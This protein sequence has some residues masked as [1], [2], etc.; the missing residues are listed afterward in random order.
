VRDTGIGIAP[1][2]LSLIFDP[3][4][5]ADASTTRHY[6]GTGL[7]M[8]ICKQLVELMGGTLGV[9]S[10]LGKGSTFWFTAVF[11]KQTD[12]ETAAAA[13]H[14]PAEESPANP[15]ANRTVQQQEPRVSGTP[16][17]LLAEDDT[18]NQVVIR[19][20]L[21][22]SG[23]Q[24]DLATNGLEAVRLLEQNDYDLVLM[25]CMMPEMDGYQATATIRD[26]SSGVRNHDLP[27]I[28][29]TANAMKEDRD[30]GLQAGKDD[31]LS[32]PVEVAELLAKLEKWL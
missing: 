25:D 4:S 11:E 23:Y 31:Y 26:R 22:R 16:R 3:F 30:L 7:G 8:A 13:K 28:A 12:Q 18:T 6:G 21:S 29:L 15:V 14:K 27:I 2:K 10:R 19:A 9:E 17:L 24:V 32:K 5:Q 20:I 1:D